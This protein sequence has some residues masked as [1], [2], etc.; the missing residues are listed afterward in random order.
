MTDKTREFL[1]AIARAFDEA[2]D[3]SVS[4]ATGRRQEKLSDAGS[5]VGS[6]AALARPLR[7]EGQRADFERVVRNGMTNLLHNVMVLLDGG[8]AFTDSH[9]LVFTVDGEQLDPG[10]H[11]LL[12]DYFDETGRATVY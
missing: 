7:D 9:S 8:T 1:E 6:C 11:E 10:L 4:L 2:V 5:P 3:N 12:I